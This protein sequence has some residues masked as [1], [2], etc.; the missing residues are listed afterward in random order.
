MEKP[1][2]NYWQLRM[3]NVKARLEANNFEVFLAQNSDAAVGMVMQEIIPK[4]NPA[5]V[6]WGGS[7]T[8]TS[9][10]LNKCEVPLKGGALRPDL[11]F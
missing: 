6:S 9:V 4:I 1:I 5:S 8:F 7:M 3:S 11:R 10:Y 2:E